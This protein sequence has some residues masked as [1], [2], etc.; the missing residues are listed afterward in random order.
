MEFINHIAAK[1]H[2]LPFMNLVVFGNP[3]SRWLSAIAISLFIFLLLRLIVRVAQGRLTTKANKT[4]TKIDDYIT[5]FLADVRQ[6]VLLIIALCIGMNVLEQ[7][8]SARNTMQLILVIA[9]LFQA[10][11]WAARLVSL[12]VPHYFGADDPAKS[13]AI[14]LISFVGQVV[15]WSLVL[16]LI[17]D[18]AGVNITALVAGLGVGG[19]A[20]ALAVQNILGDLLGSLSIVLDKP[21]QVGDFIIVGDLLGTVERIGIKTTRVK[22]LSGEQLIFANSDLLASRVRNFKRMEERRVVFSIGVTY[23]TPAEK[24]KIVPDI[25]TSAINAEEQTRFDRCHFKSY[26]DFALIFEVVYYVLAPDYNLYM[27]IQQ[28]I[29]L[30]IYTEFENQGIEFAYPTQTIFLEKNSA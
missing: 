17:L 27:D 24:L 1:V 10:G 13:S 16:I 3:V 14:G 26:G 21:F 7:S 30:H 22:S 5:E 2:S 12:L 9:A 20:V 29:N 6:W 25:I 18:N 28:R 15:V 11:L 23:Q 4:E 19:I 8:D